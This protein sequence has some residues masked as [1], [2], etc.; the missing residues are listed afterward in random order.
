[1]LVVVEEQEEDRK[2]GLRLPS[3]TVD[4]PGAT[5]VLSLSCHR[6]QDQEESDLISGQPDDMDNWG[7]GGVSK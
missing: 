6:R 1:M 3:P 5:H 2:P 7:G 4:V